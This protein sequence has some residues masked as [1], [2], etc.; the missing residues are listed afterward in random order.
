MASAGPPDIGIGGI[1][2]DDSRG[3]ASRRIGIRIRM[4]GG[5]LH[6]GEADRDIRDG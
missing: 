6:H 4:D 1:G 3:G 5:E 2:H